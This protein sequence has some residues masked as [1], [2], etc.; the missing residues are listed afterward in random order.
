MPVVHVTV[1][2]VTFRKYFLFQFVWPPGFISISVDVQ[3]SLDVYT[4]YN[5]CTRTLTVWSIQVFQGITNCP[6]FP[7][8][9]A[10]C[11]HMSV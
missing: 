11:G 8:N 5:Y 4:V 9:D 2:V 7:Q 10:N 1:Y 3:Q 6:L